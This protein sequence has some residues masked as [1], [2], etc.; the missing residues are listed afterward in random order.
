MPDFPI[1]DAHVHLWDPARFRIPWL[2]G[3]ALLD[4]PY[5]LEEYRAHTAG[6]E[7][8]ALVYLQV[9]VAPAY[10]LLEAQFVADLA[11]DDRRIKAIVAWAP[12]EDGMRAR[13]YLDAL[14]KI[15]PL[16]KGVRRIVQGESDP[17]FS[18]RPDFVRGT[19]LLA[20]YGLSCDIC[21][22]HPQL[23]ATIELVRQCPQ[24]QF[25]LD[26]L[27]K[28][29]IKDHLLEPWRA[30]LAELAGLPNVICKI[31]GAATEADHQGWQ[32]EDLE[33]YIAHA[34]AVFGED[35]VAFGGDWPVVLMAAP[36]S[37]WVATL[38][39]LTAQLAPEAKRKLWAENARRFY[40]L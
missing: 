1:V 21:I 27:G 31:S 24:V 30:Q 5:L 12:L 15:S 6:V 28:P 23:A 18:L 11:R 20:D 32:A 10:S 14:V 22:Y 39:A 33:P 29:A 3:N 17:N 40:R 36:Y 26:H 34:L 37:R 7:V 4:Q 19:Q 35:R 9:E 16:V 2:D 8:E 25:I 13:S 38:D